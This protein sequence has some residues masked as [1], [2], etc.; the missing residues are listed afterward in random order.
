MVV[1]STANPSTMRTTKTKPGSM[2]P[3]GG[4]KRI[5]QDRTQSDDTT[6]KAMKDPNWRTRQD[7]GSSTDIE[8]VMPHTD[9]FI[10]KLYPQIDSL[11]CKHSSQ[12]DRS[13]SD[14][15]ILEKNT[16]ESSSASDNFVKIIKK[17][18]LKPVDGRQMSIFELEIHPAPTTTL[19]GGQGYVKVSRNITSTQGGS[20][21][22]TEVTASSQ[23][24]ENI[25]TPDV[26]QLDTCRQPISS[27]PSLPQ[28]HESHRDKSVDMS[29]SPSCPVPRD[30]STA[31]G[32]VKSPQTAIRSGRDQAFQRLI[33]RLNRD[34]HTT[35]TK[36]SRSPMKAQLRPKPPGLEYTNMFANFRRPTAGEGRR[37]Q[38]ISDFKVDY[39]D[40]SQSSV[41][42]REGSESTVQV[43]NKQSTW[44]PKAREFLSLGYR[45]NSRRPLPWDTDVAA[46]QTS[47][48][49]REKASHNLNPLP[50]P[51]SAAW[52]KANPLPF[53]PYL[54]PQ[55]QSNFVNGSLNVPV[56][57]LGAG[58]N[59]GPVPETLDTPQY[60]AGNPVSQPSVFA[61]PPATSIQT[62]MMPFGNLT[63]QQIAAAQQMAAL[64]YLASLAALGPMPLLT[65][66]ERPN[67]PANSQRPPVPKPVFPN[68]GAQLAYEEWI[69]WRKANEPGYAVECKARQQR[70]SQR[71]KLPKKDS[72]DKPESHL[73][74]AKAVAA[75]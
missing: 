50:Q 54:T 57:P 11:H 34:N 36:P 45:Q 61:V 68:A 70:R 56:A 7:T 58:F 46:L 67:F 33:Q 73:V 38:T 48:T 9:Q 37:N 43:S 24:A 15:S 3:V 72:G 27:A 10:S 5:C 20:S 30:R 40:R 32:P 17:I 2:K 53:N 55:D 14:F 18:D 19:T 21:S 1:S 31:D 13:S 28:L 41:T 69:E 22:D 6:P 16:S 66:L 49:L 23:S 64:P 12:D 44:N 51:A 47:Q 71:V 52:P 42:S 8:N 60:L 75:A 65:G 62:P 25:H 4:A 26:F 35:T 39:W 74:P 59:L 63:A 29:F